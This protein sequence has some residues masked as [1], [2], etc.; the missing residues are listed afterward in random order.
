MSILYLILLVI[1]IVWFL[2][3]LVS[4]IQFFVDLHKNSTMCKEL[5]SILKRIKQF[6]DDSEEVENNE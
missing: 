2:C 3:S 6:S 1:F 5:K 4:I